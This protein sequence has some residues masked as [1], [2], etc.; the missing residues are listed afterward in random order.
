[1]ALLKHH[2][3]KLIDDHGDIQGWA[4]LGLQIGTGT[5]MRLTYFLINQIGTPTTNRPVTDPKDIRPTGY[6]GTLFFRFSVYL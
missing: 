2:V 4:S 5:S 6:C 3:M 1:M